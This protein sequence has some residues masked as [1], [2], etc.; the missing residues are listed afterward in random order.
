MLKRGGLL[1]PVRLYYRSEFMIFFTTGLK[2]VCL[3]LVS[4]R[5]NFLYITKRVY[6]SYMK[7]EAV[8]SAA[9]NSYKPFVNG[10]SL[11]MWFWRF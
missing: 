3:F 11:I 5:I 10:F 9:K 8:F 1:K 4:G 2:C 7:K 6:A